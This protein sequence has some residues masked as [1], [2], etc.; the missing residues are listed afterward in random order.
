[1][2]KYYGFDPAKKGQSYYFI[3]KNTQDD[4]RIAPIALWLHKLGLNMWYDYGI[5]YNTQWEQVVSSHIYECKAVILFVTKGMFQKKNESNK[6]FTYVKR[7]YNIAKGTGK[8]I[9][10]IFLDNIRW[11]EVPPDHAPWFEELK[12]IQGIV[13]HG[14][15]DEQLARKI[16]HM[17]TSPDGMPIKETPVPAPSEDLLTKLSR[18]IAGHRTAFA[19]LVMCVIAAIAI[20]SIPSGGTGGAG[21]GSSCIGSPTTTRTTPPDGGSDEPEREYSLSVGDTFEFGRYEQDNN[22]SNG[23]EAIVWQVLDVKGDKAFII[24]EKALNTIPFNEIRMSI[25]WPDCSLRNWLNGEF[26]E[27][28]FTSAEKEHICLT[29]VNAERPNIESRDYIFCLSVSEAEDYF[30]TDFRRM[31]Y[32][33]EYAIATGCEVNDTLGTTWW[34]LRNSAGYEDSAQNIRTDGTVRDVGHNVNNSKGAVRPAMWIEM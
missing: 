27:E 16:Y 12:S 31:A 7:E 28:S 24:S 26:L 17:V 20:V 34:W 29:T 4:N 21:S 2:G 18:Y 11:S 25:S 33:T 22:K 23:D 9:F 30:A 6:Y 10:I 3:S 8:Q 32:P 5:P 13:R 1:M 19:V 15:S 14:E